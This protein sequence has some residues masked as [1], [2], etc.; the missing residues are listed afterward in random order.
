MRAKINKIL[1]SAYDKEIVKNILSSYIEIQNNYLL[2]KWKASELDAG[3]FVESVRRAI[4][5]ELFGSYTPFSKNL[6]RFNDAVLKKYE[7]GKGSE[8]IRILIPRVL[9]SV[10]NIRNKRGVGHV[11]AISPNEMDSTLILYSV[12]WVLSELIRIK[13]TLSIQ[14]T[15]KLINDIVQRQIELLWETGKIKRVLDPKMPAVKQVLVLLLDQSPLY[16]DKLLD[17]IEYKNKTNFRKLLKYLHKKRLIEYRK[18]R[19][20]E[21]TPLGIK[22]AEKIILGKK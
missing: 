1:G 8:S 7:Q 16:E 20:C 4:E 15:Q 22:E 11:G 19:F 3:H 18:D 17:Y 14:E 10:Y 6:P 13:S 5:L 2:K 21:I 12:K 9:K